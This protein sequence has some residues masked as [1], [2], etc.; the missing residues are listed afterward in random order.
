MIR[1]AEL[2]VFLAPVAAFFLWRLALARGL[3]GPPPR[4]L[5][6][7][8]ASLIALAAGLIFFAERD[9]LPPGRYIPARMDNGQIVPGHSAAPAAGP[10]AGP[11]Q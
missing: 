3:D 1:F 6:F 2:A 10:A 11:A 8:F 7:I 4:Q 9:R 5:A